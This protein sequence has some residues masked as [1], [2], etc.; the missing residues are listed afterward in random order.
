[1]KKRMS[2]KYLWVMEM[3]EAIRFLK[4]TGYFCFNTFFAGSNSVK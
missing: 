3:S 4:F 1:M 2:G